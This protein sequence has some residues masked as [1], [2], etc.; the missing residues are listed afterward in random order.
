MPER[1]DQPHTTAPLPPAARQAIAR[2]EA[3]LTPTGRR[4]IATGYV[5]RNTTPTQADDACVLCGYWTCRCGT[6]RPTTQTL[7]TTAVTA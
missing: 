7:T 6:T 3:A 2:L 1:T 5:R 4:V